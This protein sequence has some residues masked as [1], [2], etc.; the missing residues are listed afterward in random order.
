MRQGNRERDG[1]M[2]TRPDAWTARI[3]VA[4]LL[5]ALCGTGVC[6]TQGA[7]AAV[8]DV[9]A[10]VT[11]KEE[12]F[13]KGPTIWLG[14][15]ADIEG[16]GA[17]VLASIEV[18]SAACPGSTKRF[19]SGLLTA[20]IR[21]SG[22]GIDDVEVTGP[23]NVVARTLHIEV[24]RKAVREDLRQFI[25]AQMP[26][27]PANTTIDIVPPP[28]DLRVPQGDVMIAWRPN[29]DYRWAGSTT[30]QG[31]VLVDGELQRAF[32]C[33][34]NIESYVDV[35]V[36]ATDITRGDRIGLNDLEVQTRA[37]SSLRYG[38][39]SE[40]AEAIGMVARSTIFPGQIVTKRKIEAPQLV[41]RHQIVSVETR[42]GGLFV[43]GR[44]RALN[45]GCAGDVIALRNEGSKEE[46]RGVVREDG[47]VVVQ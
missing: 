22:A 25:E 3:S 33:K 46:F 43:R 28:Q 38:H 45:H 2:K 41:K 40:P 10:T 44:A 7:V 24:S 26:W 42:V 47:V 23:P 16:E 20:R 13:V 18:G 8:G 34:V 39:L 27:D 21:N 1:V 9:G 17:D 32:L 29:P 19:N 11:L 37:L 12:A 4:V 14:D 36:A 31:E 35:L 15:I 6:E 30:F 5:A